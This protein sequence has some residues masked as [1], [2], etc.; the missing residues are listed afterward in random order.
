MILEMSAPKDV[1]ILWDLNLIA[2]DSSQDFPLFTRSRARQSATNR[3]SYRCGAGVLLTSSAIC[4]ARSP[5]ASLRPTPRSSLH[6][7]LDLGEMLAPVV[8][9]PLID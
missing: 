7:A 8:L 3:Q 6:L 5:G 2:S 4:T 9:I 1:S